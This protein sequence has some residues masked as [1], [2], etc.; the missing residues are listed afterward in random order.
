[1]F[2]MRKIAA[3]SVATFA[4]A[5]CS[6][7]TARPTA[8]PEPTP[9]YVTAPL[10]GMQYLEGSAEAST[11]SR[12]SVACKIDNSEAARPQLGLNRT[13]I[14]FVEMVEG[15]LT[16]LVAL[17]HSTQPT[18]VG[19][20][21]SIR[22]MDP[23]ILSP[24]G[25]IVCYSGGQAV[26]VN[27]MRNTNVFNASETTEQDKGTFS[28]SKDRY[29]PH[30]VIVDVDKLAAAHPEIAA[31]GV[32]FGFASEMAN[33]TAALTGTS[34]SDIKVYF[35]LALSQWAPNA[36]ATRFLRTQ[37][38]EIH[39]DAADG[40]QISAANVVIMTVEIDRSY[41]DGRYGN[42][43]RS[44]MIG[45][46]QAQVCSA[47]SCVAAT[48]SKANQIAPITLTDAAGNPVLLAPGNTWVELQAAV[49]ESKTVLTFK[50]LPTATATPK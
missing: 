33:S 23:D 12:P 2:S 13:D 17:W 41:L 36:E 9:V 42:V 18:A 29:A 44:V 31:P 4:L 26:F 27:M 46:G 39:T 7:P 14:V 25:G 16:R 28:R 49:P 47:G 40:S 21:R 10:T 6:G 15:G 8:E 22:P 24:F 3:I 30:N 37:D 38:G 20:V 43:P 34:V 19:P 5:A 50:P 48:W 35:P 32:Q 1:M 11:L 45:S